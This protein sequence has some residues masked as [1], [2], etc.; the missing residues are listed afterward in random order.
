MGVE[1]RVGVFVNVLVGGFGVLVWLNV[2]VGW[3]VLPMVTIGPAGGDAVKP[4]YKES[5]AKSLPNA[6]PAT[7]TI[8]IY[9]FPSLGAN[10]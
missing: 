1:V 3:G 6:G 8:L 2:I 7:L 9:T 10:H 5:M 4:K